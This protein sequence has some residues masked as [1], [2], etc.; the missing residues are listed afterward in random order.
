MS[1][2]KVILNQDVYNL[3]EEGDVCEV[4]KGYARNYLIPKKLAVPY[5]KE[6]VAIFESRR[7]AIEKRKE[8]KRRSA[9]GL[10]GQLEGAS[11]VLSMTAG[12][13]GKL[14]GSVTNTMVVEELKKMGIEVEKKKVEVPS[15]AIKMLGDYTIRV[16][17]Y[18]NEVAE[19]KLTVKDVH[20]KKEAAEAEEAAARKAVQEVFEESEIDDEDSIEDEVDEEEEVSD[21][22][23]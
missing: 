9:L 7:E 17:L 3:G 4:A 14:F 1:G 15:S 6:T 16:K 10:K 18:E 2:T 8:E 23:E 20:A 5:S 13:S 21:E 12:D 22:E 19:V 11:I